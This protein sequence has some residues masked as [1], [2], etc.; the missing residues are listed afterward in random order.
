V[1]AGLIFDLD[2]GEQL[3]FR[4][5]RA[6][7]DVIRRNKRDIEA[8]GTL[9]TVERVFR[10]ILVTEYWLSN[11]QALLVVTLSQTPKAA[12]VRGALL[13]ERN[14]KDL[15]ITIKRKLG[16]PYKHGHY[17]TRTCRAWAAM[18]NRCRN[19]KNRNWKDYGGRGIKVCERWDDFECF[20]ADMGEAPP[21]L[22]LDRRDNNG[23]YEPGNYRWT[24][25]QEQV[26]NRRVKT[27]GWEQVKEIRAIVG[28]SQRKIAAE[29]GVSPSAISNILR[30]ETYKC[31]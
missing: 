24:T 10:K 23:N 4:R 19:P 3:G 6:I 25:P 1:S 2:L 22:S 11:E 5:P 14:G 26:H 27:L 18:R 21:G 17:G 8:C 9:H 15:D 28:R 16:F 20:L 31:P 29:Y 30:G 7:R 13:E 12:V